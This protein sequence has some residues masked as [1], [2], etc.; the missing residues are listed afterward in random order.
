MEGEIRPQADFERRRTWEAS[1][2]APADAEAGER[3]TAHS[4]ESD[5]VELSSESKDIQANASA[6]YYHKT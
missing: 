1:H 2:E 6:A 5:K 4:T 3:D